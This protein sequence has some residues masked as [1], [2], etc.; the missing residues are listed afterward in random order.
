MR[1][2]LTRT[3]P[4]SVATASTPGL[5]LA[6]TSS[7]KK[8]IAVAFDV[9]R[10]PAARAW[11][12]SIARARAAARLGVQRAARRVLLVV[13]RDARAGGGAGDLARGAQA[14]GPAADHAG[15]DDLIGG[16]GGRRRVGRQR[17]GAAHLAHHL[18]EHGV[19]GPAARHQRVVVHPARKQPVGGRQQ[20]DVGAGEGVL[21]FAGEPGAR[22]HHAGAPVGPP[23]D[24]HGTGG[25]VPVEAEQA[26][27]AVVLGRAPERADAGGE[28]RNG[29]RLAGRR[30][31]RRPLEV[32]RHH[33][34][35]R[36]RAR[37]APQGLVHARHC[38]WN[39]G[40]FNL[41]RSNLRSRL[42][43]PYL[44]RVRRVG[45]DRCVDDDLL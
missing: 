23:V 24:A 43:V 16:R 30:G 29:D 12:A 14:G 44:S 10:T 20:V 27:R 42:R 34:A 40:A 32:D 19:A 13:E 9:R 4:A 1:R 26:A 6:P 41:M 31:N 5:P 36:R 35:R 21:P 38:M 8:P 7:G 15:V 18:Q 22:R 3:R 37:K 2:A 28:Q 11:S 25:A 33:L 39:P 45:K 17:A